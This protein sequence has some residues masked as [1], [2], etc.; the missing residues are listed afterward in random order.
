MGALIVGVR[1]EPAGRV[2]YFATD[3]SAIDVGDAV[4]A[5]AED[6]PRP[7]RVVIAPRQIISAELPESLPAL[8]HSQP[9]RPD[10]QPR[11]T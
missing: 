8:I 3:D 11:R 1:F 4:L 5:P 7:G 9:D 10:R 6:G 2:I